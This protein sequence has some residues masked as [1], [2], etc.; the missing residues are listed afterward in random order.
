MCVIFTPVRGI[1]AAADGRRTIASHRMR[2]TFAEPTAVEP[3]AMCN[4]MSSDATGCPASPLNNVSSRPTDGATNTGDSAAM[5][6]I[7]S[8]L[9]DGATEATT[10]G[11]SAGTDAATASPNPV[12]GYTPYGAAIAVPFSN[13]DRAER[14]SCVHSSMS[15]HSGLPTNTAPFA[16]THLLWP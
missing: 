1:T 7:G 8:G 4:A 3:Q 12:P 2:W 5:N 13:V 11:P 9:K 10:A 6:T 14:G 15:L 16:S